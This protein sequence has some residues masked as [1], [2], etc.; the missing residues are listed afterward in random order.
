MLPSLIVKIGADTS[1]AVDGFLGVEKS[2]NRL[3][4]ASTATANHLKTVGDSLQTYGKKLSLISVGIAAA[5]TAAFKMG[6]GTAAAAN[7]VDKQSKAVGVSAESYQELAFAIG[8]VSVM[9]TDQFSNALR[10]LNTR[11][12]QA[13]AGSELMQDAFAA[14]GISSDDIASGLV[15][16]ETAFNAFVIA[17]QN[18]ESPTEAAALAQALM[19]EEAAKLGPIMRASGD[20]MDALR[21]QAHDVGAVMSDDLV[22]AGAEFVDKMA[23]V[24]AQM[25]ALR[26]TVASELIPVFVDKLIPLLQQKIIPALAE[27]AAGV[28]DAIQW[29]GD[30]PAPVQEAAGAIALAL[31]VGGPVLIAL[32]TIS[33]AL[34]ALL[35]ATGPVGLFIVAAA[36]M[37]AAWLKWG[38]DIKALLSGVKGWFV[39][40]FNSTLE[41]MKELPARFLQIG[42][43]IIQGLLDGISAKWEEVKTKFA[44]L[45]AWMP[46]WMRGELETHSPSKVFER[47]GNDIGEGLANGI[48]NSV[49]MVRDA[50]GVVTDGA[51][52]ETKGMVSSVLG[53][54]S[55][56]FKGSKKLAIAQA[57][58]NTWQGA[59]EA[60]KLPFPENLA[61]FATTL[62]T[63]MGA[64]Q[65]IK[66]TSESGGGGGAGSAAGGAGGAAAAPQTSRNVAIQLTGGDM[67]SRSQVTGLINSINEAVEDGAIVRLV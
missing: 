33:A 12:G 11:L 3:Q 38:D 10:Q 54:M 1:E 8:Q 18:T 67:F 61:A 26:N 21:E 64:V 44:E 19:G 15:D 40:A 32:G 34:S 37:S 35:L 53:S 7:A 13:G 30:L 36:L 46:E 9:S 49:G 31:G 63:G 14:I 41:W 20:Q 62:A 17:A 52:G 6:S 29:F 2:L 56:L 45:T 39:D 23:E 24:N 43:D 27:V 42:T 66:G 65:S 5:T 58:V 4:R 51:M 25:M 47:I 57:L 28:A 50:L 48:S 59:T 16:A 22:K 55:Q 60:L